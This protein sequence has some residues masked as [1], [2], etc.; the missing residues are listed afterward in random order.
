MKI[1]ELIPLPSEKWR[2]LHSDSMYIPKC[3]GCYVLT[4]F[5]EDI[6]YIGLTTNLYSRFLQH[7]NNKEKTSPTE[8]GKAIWFFYHKLNH[9]ELNKIE[10]TW[11]NRFNCVHG[12][13]PILNKI[14][15]PLS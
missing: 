14:S 2:F 10:R 11:I 5:D 12:R 4:T 3:S 6:L 1:S 15:S 13:N 8:E 9:E 7:L